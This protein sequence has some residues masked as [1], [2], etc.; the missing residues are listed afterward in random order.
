MPF[1]QGS[2]IGIGIVALDTISGQLTL[3]EVVDGGVNPTYL[4]TDKNK[5]CLYAT[6]ECYGN[7]SFVLSYAI[8]PISGIY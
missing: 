2:A 5:K 8:D 3:K 6:N 4:C 1:V 7:D